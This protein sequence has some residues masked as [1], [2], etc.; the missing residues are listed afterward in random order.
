MIVLMCPKLKFIM[1][2]FN[3]RLA[4]EIPSTSNST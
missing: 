2:P 1:C 3:L 4:L